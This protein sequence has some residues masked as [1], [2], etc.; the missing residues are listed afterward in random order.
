[1]ATLYFEIQ[2]TPN[3]QKFL[4]TLASVQYRLTLIYR[5]ATEGG[6]FLDISDSSDTPILHGIPLVTG[7]DLLEPYPDLN[8][9]GSLYVTT[10]GDPIAVPT[11]D[12]L[13]T[14]SHLYFA[15][16]T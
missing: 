9:G 4:I 5:T 1:M 14:A 12:N 3:A 2:L 13:G 7:A 8:F 6:W 15:V 16:T 11:F 10:D